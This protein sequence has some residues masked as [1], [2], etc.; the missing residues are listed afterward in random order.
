MYT[1]SYIDRTNVS[2]AFD[3]KLSGAMSDLGMDDTIKGNAIGLFFWG[4]MVL[5]I[6]GG[7]LANH[8]SAKRI[9]SIFLIFWGV[10]AV[11]CGFVTNVTQFKVMR[12]LLGVAESGVYPATLVLLANWFPRSERGRANAYWTLCQP[13]AVA[14]AAPITGALLES[15]SWRVAL[16]VEG[17]LPFI[18]L[19]IWW[20]FIADKPRDAKWISP[21]ERKYL[22]TTL[23]RE[24]AEQQAPPKAPLW[25]S[26]LHPAVFLLI[27]IYFFMNCAVYGC[28]TFL[29]TALPDDRFAKFAKSVLYAVP[30]LVAAV[31]MV[32]ASRSSD[33]TQERRKHV[34]VVFAIG[35]LSLIASVVTRDYFWLSFAFLCL[36]IAG[37]FAGIPLFWTIPAETM[38][39]AAVGAVMGLVNAFGNVGGWAG[40]YV[41]GILKQRT[42]GT[43]VPFVVLGCGLL[44][45]ATFVMCLPKIKRATT[46][47]KKLQPAT[48]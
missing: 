7:Y 25:K 1:I 12:F 27:P 10:C 4:Y 43:N 14:V 31:A 39:I 16:K 2:L 5:Q 21:E 20:Y 19:P 30:Y 46:A 44:I 8:W 11:G 32:V 41:F 6:P 35:G 29:S 15:Y 28:N 40:N 48:K 3:P 38:P 37:P 18:W 9:V 13:L 34:A 33:R 24:A 23:A 42:G 26:L 22:E 17:V 45:A 36:A 47:E